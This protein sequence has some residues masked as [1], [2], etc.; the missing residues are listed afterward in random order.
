MPNPGDDDFDRGVSLFRAMTPALA[1]LAPVF[2]LV[3]AMLAI[4]KF[5][6]VFTSFPPNP[7]DLAQAISDAGKA[8]QK[9]VGMVP[10]VSVPLLIKDLLTCMISFLSGV[11]QRLLKLQDQI[12]RIEAARAL[13][14]ELNLP[15]LDILMDCAEEN[16]TLYLQHLSASMGSFASLWG[17]LQLFAEIA[18]LDLPDLD[19]D[20][21]GDLD[22]VIDKLSELVIRL[23]E[24]LEALP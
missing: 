4:K 11:L 12:Q 8:I 18:G 3:E 19:F 2:T 5:I 24:I 14:I 22:T 1:A 13:G 16:V 6:D 21:S 17:I 20:V 23:Q 7:V 9:L 15:D 10:A